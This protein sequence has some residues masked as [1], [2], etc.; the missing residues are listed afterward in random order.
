MEQSFH[1]PTTEILPPPGQIWAYFKNGLN[2]TDNYDK[3]KKATV[4]EN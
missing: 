4:D 3:R 1:L 2:I